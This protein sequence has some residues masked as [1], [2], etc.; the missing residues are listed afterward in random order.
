[1]AKKRDK[2]RKS[3]KKSLFLLIFTLILMLCAAIGGFIGCSYLTKDDGCFLIGEK[4]I[5][6][7]VGDEYE[8]Q[9]IKVIEFGRK[10]SNDKIKIESN[11]DT[12]K[13]GEYIVTYTIESFRFNGKNL[14]R[15]VNVV[16]K[17]DTQQP[18]LPDEGEKP[19]EGEVILDGQLSVHFLELGNKYTGDSV[20]I[21]Y[22]DVDILIDAGSRY[23][24]A[25]TIISYLENY[26][27]DNTLEYVIATHGHQDHIAAFS[28]TSTR[29]GIFE[30]F[31]TEVIIDF[32]MT[33]SSTKVVENYYKYRDLEVQNGAKHWTALECYNNQNGAQRV[34]QIG[35]GVELEILYNYYYENKTSDENDYS[36]CVMI[37]QGDN[38]YLFTGDLEKKGEEKLV[39][40]YEANGGLPHCVLYK[41]GHHGSGTSSNPKLLQAITPDYVCVCACAGSDEYTTNNE[42]QFPTQAFVDNIA[43]YTDKV[44]VTTMIDSEGN[45]VSMNG[46]IVFI[47]NKG[48]FSVECSNN[49]TLL[50]DT[51]WFKEKRTMP[52]EWVA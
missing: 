41:A 24:S 4:T 16:E 19:G 6:L 26:V 50:K 42:N 45:A 11:V 21:K 48:K 52:N 3:G 34:Y 35:E 25:T 46:N 37:N 5:T 32:P 31:D 27:E 17:D 28:S 9:G 1:M 47:L 40:Y 33:N 22:G 51:Q 49:N 36:V 8:D 2:Q 15:N 13:I 38:H 12:S 43:K 18:G 20:Y 30:R 23:D 10:V 14:V 39:E 29:M 7:N 44:F